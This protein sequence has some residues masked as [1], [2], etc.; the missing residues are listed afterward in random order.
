MVP[1][2]EFGEFTEVF[3][4]NPMK[5]ANVC[6]VNCKGIRF[7][8]C[9]NLTEKIPDERYVHM[10]LPWV[11]VREINEAKFWAVYVPDAKEIVV[12]DEYPLP[13]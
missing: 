6:S 1:S 10:I 9:V 13:V 4:G 7:V 5:F 11:V 8:N 12:P 2:L 3:N